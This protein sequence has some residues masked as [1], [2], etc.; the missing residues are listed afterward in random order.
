MGRTA[1]EGLAGLADH[2]FGLSGYEG[3][4]VSFANINALTHQ[5]MLCAGGL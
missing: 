1:A 4:R 5:G 2:P 3:P